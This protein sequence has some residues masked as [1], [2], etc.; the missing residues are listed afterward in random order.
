MKTTITLNELVTSELIKEGYN[1]FFNNGRFTGTNEQYAFI[2][3]MLRYDEPVRKIIDKFFLDFKFVD[4][5]LD[6]MFKRAFLMKFHNREFRYQTIE[7]VSAQLLFYMLTHETE[8]ETLYNSYE[9]MLTKTSETTS[10]GKSTS[11]QDNRHMTSKFPDTEVNIDLSDD[12]LDYADTN[13]IG[14]NKQDSDSNNHSQ[15]TS[16]DPE[17]FFKFSGIWEKYFDEID[18][19]CFLQKW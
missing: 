11:I 1:E 9:K 14:K 3:K 7:D 16:Y 2:Q 4:E 5:K 13:D 19:Q 17:V 15:S 10:T 18:G 8:I 6:T 12:T